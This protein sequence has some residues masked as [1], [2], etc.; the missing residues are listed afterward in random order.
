MSVLRLSEQG[1]YCPAGDFY[2]DPWRPVE[3]AIITHAHADHAR[4]GSRSYTCVREGAGLLA[5]RMG[6][7][8]G[9]T[10]KFCVKEYGE[11]FDLGSARVSFHPAG[12]VLGSAQVRIAVGAKVWVVSGDYKRDADPTCAPFEEIG[13][14]VFI[15]EATFGLPIY[16]WNPLNEIAARVL[17]WWED[18]A[19]AGLNSIIYA[20]SLGKAQRIMAELGKLTRKPVIVHS[21]V[22]EIARFYTGES[23]HEGFAPNAI[24][25][26][27]F[28]QVSVTQ[29]KEKLQGELIIVPPAS[30][31]TPWLRQFN[32]S[33]S[34]LASGWMQVRGNR[35]RRGVD[36]G[37]V[38]SDHADFASLI[39]TVRASRASQVLV[40]HG[41]NAVF[42]RYLQEIG[43]NASAL[44]TEFLDEGAAPELATA[45]C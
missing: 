37:F 12:H 35:R 1:L 15:T 32:P 31:G 3:R 9:Q 41:N 26:I 40:T 10:P 36:Q 6:A 42:S 19:R 27:P 14:D 34:A 4:R 2:I 11:A 7:P 28:R 18:N 5:H 16:R 39:R 21:A 38:I 23:A 13:C 33:R 30:D 20:Y 25:L 8:G 22:A 24:D 45:E 44:Q 29:K 43:I 17:N